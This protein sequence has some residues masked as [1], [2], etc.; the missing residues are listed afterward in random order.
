MKKVL[1]CLGLASVLFGADDNIKFEITPTF[2]YNVFEGNLDLD[3]RAAPGI[4]LGYHFDDFF[5]DQAE[6]G[7]EYYSGIKYNKVN[8]S[9]NGN[10]TDLTKIYL[11]AIKGVDLGERFYLYGLVGAGYDNYSNAAL[12]TSKDNKDTGFGH[13][14]AGLKF[15]ITD[16][17]A[18]RLETRDQIAF[19]DAHHQWIST[20]GISYGFGGTKEQVSAPAAKKP[21]CP[22]TPRE[23][24][25]LDENGCEKTISL[26]GHFGFDKTN[27]NP[28]FEEKIKEIAKVLDENE[29]YNTLLE[30]HTDNVGARAYNQKLSERRAESVAKELEKYGVEKNRIQTKGYG[31]DKPRSSNDT[32]EGRA[33]NRRVEAKFFLQ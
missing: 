24:A 11:N 25:L 16:S 2:N 9:A 4:R 17:V 3:N 23:G 31:P 18:L 1:L 7:L 27:I 5:L 29:R 13:Y 8:A 12:D 28:V 6:F 30:G 26:E 14:G 10:D 33:D 32:K 20:L 19:N 22:V 15:R 21:V